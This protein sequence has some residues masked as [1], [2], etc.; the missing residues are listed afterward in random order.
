MPPHE[1][2]TNVESATQNIP[3]YREAMCAQYITRARGILHLGAHLGKEAASYAMH[4]KPVLWVEAIPEVHAQLLEHLSAFPEQRAICALLGDQDGVLTSFNI[5]SNSGGASS[6]IYEFGP[7]AAGDKS[8]WPKLKLKMVDQITLPMVRLDSMFAANT[9]DAESYDHWVVDL[10]GAEKLALQGAGNVLKACRSLLIEV[11]TAEVYQNAVL[12]PELAAWLDEQGFVP[13]WQP[14]KQHDDILFVRKEEKSRAV[15]VFRADAY[16]QHT[17]RRL[18]HLATLG[19]DLYGKRVLEVGAGVGDHTSFYLDRDCTVTTSDARPENILAMQERFAGNPKV[20]IQ[21]LDLDYPAAVSGKYDIV[22]CY[23]LLYHLKKPAEAIRFLCKHCDDLL[24]LETCVSYG[25]KAEVNLID[26]PAHMHSQA[27]SGTGCRPTRPWIMQ[28]LQQHMP[29][30]YVTQTQPAHPEFPLDW[31]RNENKLRELKRAVF[32]ASR[33]PLDDNPTLTKVLPI[34]QQ[35]FL[36]T[37]APLLG[38]QLDEL[39]EANAILM[40]QLFELEDSLRQQYERNCQL[41]AQMSPVRRSWLERLFG[42]QDNTTTTPYE[43]LTP[44]ERIKRHLSYRLGATMLRHSRNP[45]GWLIMPW[46]LLGQVIVFKQELR[47]RPPGGF[48]PAA[49]TDA[50]LHIKQ[51]LSYRLGAAMLANASSL[52]GWLQMPW[53][54]RRE[55]ANF[56]RARDKS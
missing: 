34:Q 16:M 15:D 10:Q 33:Q 27:F 37:N 12:W 9:L 18:E 25:N 11:S 38:G 2:N 20:Q 21:A 47:T 7:Y 31:S 13:L 14:A 26:E 53:T 51:H 24:V 29:H 52:K 19:L 23:G 6:S 43:K 5:S 40:S 3:A 55:I 17:Q 49:E 48:A 1:K 44:S 54:L 36:P 28:Q 39:Q 30:V 56:R 50:A 41:E 46:A 32:V 42:T 35:R 22:H 8:L 4:N 45:L